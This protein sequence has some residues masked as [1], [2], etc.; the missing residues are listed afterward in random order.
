MPFTESYSQDEQRL[1]VQLARHAVVRGIAGLEPERPAGYLIP[2]ELERPR[3]CFVTL[4]IDGQLRGCIGNLEANGALADA[5]LRNSYLAAFRDQRFEP[6]SESERQQLEY[7]I[8]VLTPM[9]PLPVSCEADLLAT[10][11]PGIDGLLFEA[12]GRRATFLPSVWEQLTQPEQFVRQL[13]LKAGLPA[14]YWSDAVQCWIYQT[15][16]IEEG[17]GD[18]D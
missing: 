14:D 15:I 1:L 6:V 18:P 8:S 2:S 7:E 17:S 11:R 13:R 16:R 3:A 10:L 5:V 4:K 9:Q 12:E